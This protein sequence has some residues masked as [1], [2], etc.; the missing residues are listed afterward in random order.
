MNIKEFVKEHKKA[1]AVGG[2]VVAGVGT[3]YL[4]KK[5]CKPKFKFTGMK[6]CK[7]GILNEMPDKVSIGWVSDKNLTRGISFNPDEVA[8]VCEEMQTIATAIKEGTTTAEMFF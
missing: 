6:P 2:A 8:S 7:I 3:V 4:V 5:G 1:I